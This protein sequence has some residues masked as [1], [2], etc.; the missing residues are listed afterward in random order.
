MFLV[1]LYEQALSLSNL[2][3]LPRFVDDQ[4]SSLLDFDHMF[5]IVAVEGSVASGKN[6]KISHDDIIGAVLWSDEDSPQDI[7]NVLFLDIILPNVLIFL[8]DQCF[9]PIFHLVRTGSFRT[10]PLYVDR[11]RR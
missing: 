6:L 11:F 7:L 2:Y 5:K 3:L 4:T 1:W 10:K 8:D 9:L